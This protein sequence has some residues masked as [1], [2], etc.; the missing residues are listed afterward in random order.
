MKKLFVYLCLCATITACQ[1]KPKPEEIQQHLK[2]AMTEFL[3][4]SVN[5]DSTRVKFRVQEVIYFEQDNG[6]ECEFKVGMIQNE[7]DTTGVMKALVTKDFA[8]VSRKL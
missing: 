3:Y 6:Y 2:K 1:K 4:N 5:N 8:K 7:K